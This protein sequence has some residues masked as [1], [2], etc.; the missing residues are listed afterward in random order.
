MFYDLLV[1]GASPSGLTAAKYASE[2]GLKTLLVEKKKDLS[3]SE[4]ANT[5][6]Y[7]MLDKTGISIPKSCIIHKTK[8]TRMYSP[9]GDY[10]EMKD[11]GFTMDRTKFDSFLLNEFQKKGG[12][13]RFGCEVTSAIIKNSKVK[14]A[15][16]KDDS[17][18]KEIRSEVLISADGFKSNLSNQ[19]G[20]NPTKHPE[21][22]ALGVQAEVTQVDIDSDFFE[23]YLG[24]EIAPGWKAAIS[25]S[26]EDSASVAVCIRGQGSCDDY[27]ERFISKSIASPKFKDAKIL[28]KMHGYDTVATIPNQI[29]SDGFMAVGGSAGQ[30]GLAYSMLA[31][32]IAA[33]TVEM[34]KNVNDFSKKVLSGYEKEWKKRMIREYKQ[35]RLVL[36]IFE[37]MGDEKLNQLFAAAKDVDFSGNVAGSMLKVLFTNIK[38]SFSLISVL[39]RSWEI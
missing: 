13:V 23:F 37:N 12:G 6:L 38:L 7:S 35:G 11:P 10:I 31:G 29:V 1:V 16:I 25:P 39:V 27:F 26:S 15:I 8:G 14:G 22:V 17:G 32:K 21:D 30:S 9:S 5:V 28:S 4:P 36:R 20:L 33:E 2:K 19:I 24:K 18:K 3:V 34:A